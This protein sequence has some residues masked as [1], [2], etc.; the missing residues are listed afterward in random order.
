MLRDLKIQRGREEQMP[1]VAE[2]QRMRRQRREDVAR[3]ILGDMV[4]AHV[5]LSV[6]DGGVQT[7]GAE[8]VQRTREGNPSAP[9]PRQRMD[10]GRQKDRRADHDRQKMR[11]DVEQRSIQR[12]E[13]SRKRDKQ[14]RPRNH[15]SAAEQRD[16]PDQQQRRKRIADLHRKALG[17]ER[18]L[19]RGNAPTAEKNF[20]KRRPADVFEKT[21]EGGRIGPIHL[22]ARGSPHDQ[23]RVWRQSEQEIRQRDQEASQSRPVQTEAAQIEKQH[24]GQQHD[25]HRMHRQRK[26][27]A[28]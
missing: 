9:G 1:F 6:P 28:Q 5:G 22:C 15:A 3:V 25:V 27:E 26:A 10:A 23:E 2:Q 8:H 21:R 18:R 13:E 16:D 12:P 14:R 20:A 11:G 24:G 19:Q 17:E 4:L 7:E